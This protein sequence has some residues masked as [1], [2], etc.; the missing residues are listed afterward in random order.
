MPA[1][2]RD[3]DPGTVLPR[4]D[5][6][7][8][9][10]VTDG[11]PRAVTPELVSPGHPLL[12]PSP[13]SCWPTTGRAAA[14]RWRAGGRP[15]RRVLR[16]GERGHGQ[17]PGHAR[18]TSESAVPADPQASQTC[19]PA[20]QLPLP[21]SIRSARSWTG[22][23][24][25]SRWTRRSWPSRSCAARPAPARRP[26]AYGP[27][28]RARRPGLAWRGRRSTAADRLGPRGG[29]HPGRGVRAGHRQCACSPAAG[30]A[31]PCQPR[32]GVRRPVRDAVMTRPR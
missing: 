16:A 19:R 5:A 23:P 2:V 15:D 27:R 13:A 8:F 18:V 7:T 22:S 29:D 6:L 12:D 28:S 3:L 31:G 1:R 24:P 20:A 9:E 4:Y 32:R 11:V 10:R 25:S 17:S 14:T 30:G 21:R 26:T